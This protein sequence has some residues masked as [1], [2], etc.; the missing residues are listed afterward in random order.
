MTA[1]A[2]CAD[3]RGVGNYVACCA[4]C[5]GVGNYAAC[6]ADSRSVGNYA[7]CCADSRGVGNYA[8]CCD[9]MFVIQVSKLAMALCTKLNT[10]V[11]DSRVIIIIR[12]LRYT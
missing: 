2:C 3:C 10:H 4:D 7:A 8:A 9:E 5:R 6:C 12:T 11:S 1:E